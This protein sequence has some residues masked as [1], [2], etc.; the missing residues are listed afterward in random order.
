MDKYV[1]KSFCFQDALFKDIAIKYSNAWLYVA[2]L[3]SPN[4]MKSLLN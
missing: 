4:L 2:I 3:L 1:A